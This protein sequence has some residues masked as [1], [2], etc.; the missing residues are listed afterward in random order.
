MKK[1]LRYKY[2]N[3]WIITRVNG[4]L[5][6]HD[7]EESKLYSTINANSGAHILTHGEIIKSPFSKNKLATIKSK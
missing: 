5:Q 6:S 7:Q 1:K 3:K 2:Y 4:N